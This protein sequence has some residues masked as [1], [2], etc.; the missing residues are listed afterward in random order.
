[1]LLLEALIESLTPDQTGDG[2]LLQCCRK[3]CLYDSLGILPGDIISIISPHMLRQ[4]HVYFPAGASAGHKYED[5]KCHITLCVLHL[6]PRAW[7]WCPYTTT[8]V[9]NYN[10]DM[11]SPTLA[12]ACC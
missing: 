9:P 2:W 3:A 7:A 4:A 8:A 10:S 6:L 12:M 11:P 5:F 1:M